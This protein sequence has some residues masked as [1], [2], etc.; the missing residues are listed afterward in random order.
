MLKA[1]SGA[2]ARILRLRGKLKQTALE[3]EALIR[4]LGE[5][6]YRQDVEATETIDG[7]D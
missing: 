5:A 6:V 3:R 2:H 7:K 1:R 4:A